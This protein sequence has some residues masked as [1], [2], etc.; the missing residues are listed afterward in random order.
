MKPLGEK[1]V[2]P[3][4][5]ETTHAAAG[6]PTAAVPPALTGSS[7]ALFRTP[8]PLTD[9]PDAIDAVVNAKTFADYEIIE[10]IARGGMGVVVRAREKKL[11]RIV[12]LKMIL[13]GKLADESDIKRFYIEAAA[14]AA[15]Q[16]PGIVPIYEV[17]NVDG[18]HFYSMQLVEGASLKER[19]SNGP[20]TAKVAAG[21]IQ[22]VAAAV[23]YAHEHSIIHRDLKP[24]N[25]LLTRDGK[26]M[27]TD[28]GL[29]KSI[30]SDDNLTQ[31]GQILGTPGYMAPEQALGQID[32]QG[33]GVDIYSLGAL[34]YFLLTGRPPF[35][36][37][38]TLET[39]D[40]VVKQTPVSPRDLNPSVPRDLE[41]ICLKCLSKESRQRYF[42]A[43][44]LAEDLERFLAGRPVIA[45]PTGSLT[46]LWRWCVRNPAIAILSA[47]V[48]VSLIAGTITS[49][50]F[51][52]LAERRAQESEANFHE[53][54]RQRQAA[55]RNYSMARKAVDTYFT[56]VSE[57]RLLNQPGLQP[58][59]QQ[60]L[61]DALKYYER[62]VAER[63]EDPS[64]REELAAAL[65]RVGLIEETV[66]ADPQVGLNALQTSRQ[67]QEDVLLE[68]S[69]SD[70]AKEIL[71]D[72]LTAISRIQLRM[73]GPDVALAAAERSLA[74]RME[75]LT[76]KS[77]NTE[78]RR[79]VAS[80]HMNLGILH[81]ERNEQQKA[82]QRIEEAQRIREQI[83]AEVEDFETR[84]D[85]GMGYYNLGNIALDNGELRQALASIEKAVSAFEL[86]VRESPED[87][88]NRSRLALCLRLRGDML[89]ETGDLAMAI[90]SYQTSTDGLRLLSRQNYAVTEYAVEFCVASMNLGA[91]LQ[92]SNDITAAV[93]AFEESLT[94]L[95]RLFADQASPTLQ[96]LIS[97]CRLRLAF[98]KYD[99]TDLESARSLLKEVIEIADD[100]TRATPE[101]EE[102]AKEA[103]Q[104]LS[105]IDTAE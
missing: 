35:Q 75:V 20:L 44:A 59:Q 3:S 49:T 21:L 65:F 50:R 18:Q 72:T 29:A 105:R 67:I 9:V 37:A 54:E 46:R 70:S 33:P 14:A 91:L 90:A 79:L 56:R 80:S 45:R 83:L 19:L 103:Q 26:P 89:A 24:E 22:Q 40:Q 28:F 63:S 43:S 97:D 2:R 42:S 104:F 25:V 96:L 7:P 47:V 34:L 6:E 12:A 30:E 62:F 13:G 71:A 60:L 55:E 77:D 100:P 11:N 39:L 101:L 93:T 53:S 86:T 15:L 81:R 61:R 31:S 73:Q 36:A 88:G 102:L 32:Q 95:E 98:A 94:G 4:T 76:G 69:A 58:L 27:V 57:N 5:S 51:A 41:T 78:F 84:R 17:G 10:E 23:H 74:L 66:N 8:P 68:N 38:S 64:V 92:E 87:L 99:L 52:F 48:A 85:I 82:I 1:E 16:H